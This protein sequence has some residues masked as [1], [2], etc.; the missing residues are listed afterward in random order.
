MSNL[1]GAKYCEKDATVTPY[2][3]TEIKMFWYGGHRK[4]HYVRSFAKMLL[5]VTRDDMDLCCNAK[6]VGVH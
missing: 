4:A 6:E 2:S 3:V 1:D 5:I